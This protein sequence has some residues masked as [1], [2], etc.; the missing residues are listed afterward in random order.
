LAKGLLF[1]LVLSI[2]TFSNAAVLLFDF[3]S[4]QTTL[5]YQWTIDTSQAPFTTFPFGIVHEIELTTAL[6]SVVTV[7]NAFVGFTNIGTAFPPPSPRV[8]AGGFSL[9][10]DLR[11]N[12]FFTVTGP[13][14]F[15]GLPSMSPE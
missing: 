13:K 5:N 9:I 14:L 11:A 1:S 15:D 12:R 7:I 2:S 3:K 10:L 6:D 4:S 8:S